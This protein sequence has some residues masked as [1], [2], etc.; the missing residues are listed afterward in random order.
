MPSLLEFTRQS[1]TVSL[2]GGETLDL[3]GLSARDLA[4]ILKRFPAIEP[5][6]GGRAAPEGSGS[7]I[8]AFPE[9]LA[10]VIALSWLRALPV[11]A[12]NPRRLVP[13]P[14]EE[15]AIADLAGVDQWAAM[16]AVLALSFPPAMS[17]PLLALFAAAPAPGAETPPAP[18]TMLPG[19]GSPS[20]S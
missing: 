16:E 20:T 5:L 3:A 2:S 1:K 19:S 7:M 9:A 14:E 11:S 8:D 13:S 17:R 12:E 15:D 6:L 10:A 18:I 4:T